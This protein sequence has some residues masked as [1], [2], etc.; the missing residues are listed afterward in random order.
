MNLLKRSGLLLIAIMLFIVIG[1]VKEGSANELPF[2][3]GSGST[4]NDYTVQ[5]S[6]Y[7]MSGTTFIQIVSADRV[8]VS[9]NTKAYNPVDNI[10]VDLILQRWDSSSGQWVDVLNIGSATNYSSS[11]VSLSKEAKVLKNSYYRVWGIHRV[12]HAGVIEQQ[13]SIS[14]YVF[15]D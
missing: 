14:T 2:S 4:L 8:K 3:V 9:G 6:K 10:K 12:M 1:A 5:A 7:F 13:A 15:V 11:I